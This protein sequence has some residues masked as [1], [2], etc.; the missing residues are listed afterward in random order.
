[1]AHNRIV[2][3]RESEEKAA[4]KAKKEEEEQDKKIAET[5]AAQPRAFARGLV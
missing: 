5:L 4:E 1:M 3:K 2:W